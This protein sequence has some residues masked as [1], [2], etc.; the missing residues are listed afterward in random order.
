MIRSNPVKLDDVAVQPPCVVY[1]IPLE[2]IEIARQGVPA[3]RL[4]KIGDEKI[5]PDNFGAWSWK[6]KGSKQAN[7]KQ[8]RSL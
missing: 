5:V 3:E 7:L 6:K 2:E 1:R 8:T 4:T